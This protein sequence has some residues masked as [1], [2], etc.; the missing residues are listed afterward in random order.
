MLCNESLDLYWTFEEPHSNSFDET[1]SAEISVWTNDLLIGVIYSIPDSQRI[2]GNYILWSKYI[3]INTDIDIYSKK[4][5]MYHASIEK[6]HTHIW[7]S[8]LT[9]EIVPLQKKI[10]ML[11]KNSSSILSPVK[12]ERTA[13]QDRLFLDQI[14]VDVMRSR[15]QLKNILKHPKMTREIQDELMIHEFKVSTAK[16]SP[17]G[18]KIRHED[19]KQKKSVVLAE[20]HQTINYLKSIHKNLKWLNDEWTFEKKKKKKTN[21]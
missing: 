16:V 12:S 9:N 4:V 14:M 3:N 11:R 20:M 6:I 13:A 15:K 18:L 2:S 21:Y 8:I 17:A 19:Y 1:E 5:I 7:K 10:L